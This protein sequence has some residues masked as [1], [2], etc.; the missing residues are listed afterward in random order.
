MLIKCYLLSVVR[1]SFFYTCAFNLCVHIFIVCPLE[2]VCG[3]VLYPVLQ[4]FV[5]LLNV[6][7][8]SLYAIVDGVFYKEIYFFYLNPLL[9]TLFYFYSYFFWINELLDIPFYL[10]F[11]LVVFFFYIIILVI[12][13]YLMHL[14]LLI[15]YPKMCILT[16]SQR[17]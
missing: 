17:T 4:G 6:W 12:A 15:V 2:G 5:F 14:W 9:V 3:R 7:S 8:F 11:F 1:T 13:L 10:Y 16:D